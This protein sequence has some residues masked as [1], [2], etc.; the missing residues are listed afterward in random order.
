MNPDNDIFGTGTVY[1]T[2]NEGNKREL[3][4]VKICDTNMNISVDLGRNIDVTTYSLFNKCEGS[5]KLI[6]VN[7][8]LPKM[9]TK[10]SNRKKHL[11]R[12][13]NRQKLYDKLKKEGRK[14]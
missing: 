10:Y 6:N 11:K 2:D 5:F 3:G 1:I 7:S 9:I 13:K 8:R 12:V 4:E 14:L